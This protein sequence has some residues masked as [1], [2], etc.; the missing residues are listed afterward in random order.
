L[1][2]AVAARLGNKHTSHPFL[3]LTTSLSTP[4]HQP[5]TQTQQ[6]LDALPLPPSFLDQLIDALGGPG[7]VAEMTGRKGRV[8]R[9]ANGRARYELRAK[10]DSN[11][12]DSLNGA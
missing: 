4:T 9:D 7:Q 8:L 1:V 11:D 6:Q 12:M 3:S 10:P 2:N 5:T